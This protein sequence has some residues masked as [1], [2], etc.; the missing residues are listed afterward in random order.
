M[1][2]ELEH[3][4]LLDL[5]L[6]TRIICLED[7]HSL[8]KE[9]LGLDEVPDVLLVVHI[10]LPAVRGFRDLVVVVLLQTHLCLI[11]LK[12]KTSLRVIDC[13]LQILDQACQSIDV[14]CGGRDVRVGVQALLVAPTLLICVGPA[15]CLEQCDHLVDL[16]EYDGER[17]VG[18]QHGHNAAEERG[19]LA[20]HLFRCRLQKSLCLLPRCCLDHGTAVDT[21]GSDARRVVFPNLEK[22][23]WYHCFN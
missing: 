8:R 12:E 19:A 6:K 7:L 10:G 4:G 21:S 14:P 17:V 22:G 11:N 1:L 2:A 5:T 9:G 3:V 13:G 16:L 23:W 20:T 15:L 18:L